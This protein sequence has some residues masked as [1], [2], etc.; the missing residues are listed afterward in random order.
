MV[1]GLSLVTLQQN[2]QGAGGTTLYT[3]EQPECDHINILKITYGIP[4]LLWAE[5]GVIG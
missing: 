4:R 5:Y 3:L 2:T 1:I